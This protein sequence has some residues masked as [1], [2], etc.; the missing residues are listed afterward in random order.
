MF[1]NQILQFCPIETVH[2]VD[3]CFKNILLEVSVSED[4][5]YF[6]PNAARKKNFDL[7]LFFVVKI[8]LFKSDGGRRMA[9]DGQ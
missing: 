8:Y 5:S 4:L 2:C 1:R 9:Y 7:I 3:Y 6:V